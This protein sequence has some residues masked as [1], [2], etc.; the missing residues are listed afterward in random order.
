MSNKIASCRHTLSKN[1]EDLRRF[2]KRI[3]GLDRFI[4]K[5]H[6]RDTYLVMQETMSLESRVSFTA[7]QELAERRGVDAR[8]LRRHLA[9][10]VKLCVVQVT[11]RKYARRSNH[12]N[13]YTFPL[14]NEDFLRTNLVSRG[15]GARVRV[16]PLPE[17]EKQT[18]TPR[19]PMA[20]RR[21]HVWTPDREAKAAP[22][23]RSGDLGEKFTHWM[24]WREHCM[25]RRLEQQM[26][27]SVG[28]YRGPEVPP[29]SEE[30]MRGIRERIAAEELR[31]REREAE[32][33]RVE[34]EEELQRKREREA[35]FEKQK[36]ES[37]E[38]PDAELQARIDALN[39]KLGV[40]R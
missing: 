39:R 16:K 26:A 7:V 17:I 5:A 21:G 20:R 32:R 9:E 22:P 1:R 37:M 13:R 18:T 27:A 4:P 33:R 30:E 25:A 38:P 11:R 29:M 2:T 24:R 35:Y 23:A 10:L 31:I 19:A 34:Q 28:S 14:L 15:G 6:L 3:H 36:R 8:T 40:R 12:T